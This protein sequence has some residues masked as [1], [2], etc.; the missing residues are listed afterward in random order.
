MVR[1][2]ASGKRQQGSSASQARHDNGSVAPGRKAPKR[3]S[4]GQLDGKSKPADKAAP[5]SPSSTTN[6][7]PAAIGKTT[8]KTANGSANGHAHPHAQTSHA[9]ANGNLSHLS[10][11]SHASAGTA[12]ATANG[13]GNGSGSGSGSGNGMAKLP[14]LELGEGKPPGLRH[15][16]SVGASSETQTDD[17]TPETPGGTGSGNATSAS[18]SASQASQTSQTVEPRQIDVNA[19]RGGSRDG[20]A[21]DFAVGVLRSLPLIDTL[22]ILFVLI[23]L[24]S[25]WL[26]PVYLLYSGLTFAP[27]ISTRSGLN[28]HTTELL[29][30]HA[31]MPSFVVVALV[32]AFILLVWL[33]LWPAAQQL[34]LDLAKPVMAATLGG[35]SAGRPR[36]SSGVSLCFAIMIAHTVGENLW[37]HMARYGSG[38]LDSSW[39]PPDWRLPPGVGAAREPSRAPENRGSRLTTILGIHI[40]MQGVI[41]YIREWYIRRERETSAATATAMSLAPPGTPGLASG[42]GSSPKL[43]S[44]G[45]G[46]A[47]TP[48]TISE[49]VAPAVD[50]SDPSVL[51]RRRKQSAYV[52]LQQPLWAALASTKVFVAKEYE[53][54]YAASE[55][56]GE[57]LSHIHDLGNAP[58]GREPRRIWVSYIGSDEVYFD[59]SVFPPPAASRT[60][61]SRVQDSD[62]ENHHTDDTEPSTPSSAVDRTNPFF[63]RVNKA[64]WPSTRIAPAGQEQ[65][66]RDEDDRCEDDDSGTQGKKWTGDIYGLRPS[67]KYTIEFVD[68]VTDH[69][70]YGTTVTTAK[71]P[72]KMAAL[73]APSSPQNRPD[74]PVTTLKTSIAASRAKLVELQANH[75]AMR[76]DWKAKIQAH[77]NKLLKLD[78]QDNERA[79]QNKLSGVRERKTRVAHLEAQ[80][81]KLQEE[82]EAFDPSPDGLNERLAE[83]E[84]LHVAEKAGLAAAKKDLQAYS[85]E[86]KA[87]TDTKTAEKDKL[88]QRCGR[89][90]T[91]ITKVEAELA[92]MIDA[93]KRG[94]NEIERRKHERD[95]WQQQHQVHESHLNRRFNE[96]QAENSMLESQVRLLESQARSMHDHQVQ[97]QIGGVYATA[98]QPYD[99]HAAAAQYQYTSGWNLNPPAQPHYAPAPAAMWPGTS[100]ATTLP[101]V[102]A[103]TS[104][105]APGSGTASSMWPSAPPGLPPNPLMHSHSF[106]QSLSQSR[107]ARA[108]SSSLLSDSSSFAHSSNPDDD[109]PPPLL[110]AQV[111]VYRQGNVG[112]PVG[113][114]VGVGRDA[115]GSLARTRKPSVSEV[116]GRSSRSGGT[117]SGSGGSARDP[118]SPIS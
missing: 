59:T 110:A 89:L 98:A 49:G 46:D 32:D 36:R 112:L 65:Q 114:P 29:D 44:A 95:V 34:I 42:D 96:L 28:I 105:P 43:G 62:L 51:K 77:N 104:A 54:I 52:R 72:V 61:G 86:V 117:G 37:W 80:L 106:S 99:A 13:S 93:N 27:T 100:D 16:A 67:S 68:S 118:T 82:L 109:A 41:R 116:S 55:C 103:P 69:I 24:P 83:A 15:R 48:A 45:A 115:K 20:G 9:C 85:D 38:W 79:D 73:E 1:G 71:G 58:F 31:T 57:D 97:S 88:Q 75:A 84:R 21:F 7:P 78:S 64:D 91:R 22:A 14:R 70:L 12:T 111:S 30:W 8:A 94:L 102:M 66:S 81:A 33:F 19:A 63:V 53:L 3:K 11:L 17:M 4:Q 18:A 60:D 39:L 56:A 2:S 47:S 74:S 107:A 40:L 90:S 26:G 25:H 10:H 76:K 35:G 87:A 101:P 23:H 108:R 5:A 92:D 50:G 113:L 6:N